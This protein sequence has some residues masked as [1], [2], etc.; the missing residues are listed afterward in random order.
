MDTAGEFKMRYLGP[1]CDAVRAA[2]FV[3]GYVCKLSY[4]RRHAAIR[5]PHGKQA[6]DEQYSLF[7]LETENHSQTCPQFL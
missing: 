1:Y 6:H 3:I 4:V 7:P 2:A 5:T